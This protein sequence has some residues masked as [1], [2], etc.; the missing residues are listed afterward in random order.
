MNL[1]LTS[2]EKQSLEKQHKRTNLNPIERLGKVMNE[3]AHN[4]RFFH[5]VQEFHQV[6]L[7]FFDVTWP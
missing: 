5:S 3:Y 7:S 2:E 4:N 1:K 6:I